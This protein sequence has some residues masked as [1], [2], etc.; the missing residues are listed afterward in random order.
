MRWSGERRKKGSA[1]CCREKKEAAWRRRS[2]K[3]RTGGRRGRKKTRDGSRTVRPDPS[4]GSWWKQ[5]TQKL[6]CIVPGRGWSR[7]AAEREGRGRR[8]RERTGGSYAPPVDPCIPTFFH[9]TDPTE[10]KRRRRRRERGEESLASCAYTRVTRE[11]RN[12][13]GGGEEEERKGSEAASDLI[14]KCKQIYIVAKAPPGVSARQSQGNRRVIPLQD[15]TLPSETSSQPV[16]STDIFFNHPPR[17]SPLDRERSL[18][19]KKKKKKNK[20]SPLSSHG[21]ARQGR[22]AWMIAILKWTD[23]FVASM[24]DAAGRQVSLFLSLFLISNLK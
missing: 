14:F 24:V 13:E 8:N 20:K 5:T 23:R 21:R 3:E 19:P 1:R 2:V 10:K 17:R 16:H 12:I 18:L 15:P 7:R 4:S 11:W 9:C 6:A 22:K